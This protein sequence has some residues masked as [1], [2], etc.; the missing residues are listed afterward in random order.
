MGSRSTGRPVELRLKSA[1]EYGH[2]WDAFCAVLISSTST[3][4]S[5]VDGEVG[6]EG[7]KLEVESTV[8]VKMTC[9]IIFPSEPSPGRNRYREHYIELDARAAI[10]NEDTVYRAV[11]SKLCGM[12]VPRSFGLSGGVLG[13]DARRAGE[14]EVWVMILED[15]GSSLSVDGLSDDGRCV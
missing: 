8:I 12:V 14:R 6:G 2:L 3:S 13:L 5:T 1:L 10:L 9:P 11:A 4:T 7:E 15:C